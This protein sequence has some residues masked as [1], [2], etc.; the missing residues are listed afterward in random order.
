[1]QDVLHDHSVV[2]LVE[3][4]VFS[5]RVQHN[6]L[7]VRSGTFKHGDGPRWPADLST[8]AAVAVSGQQQPASSKQ[9]AASNKQQATS[10]NHSAGNHSKRRTASSEPCTS[11]SG[12]VNLDGSVPQQQQHSNDAPTV[13]A[14]VPGAARLPFMMPSMASRHSDARRTLKP[15]VYTSGSAMYCCTTNGLPHTPSW[16]NSFKP[17]F[18]NTLDRVRAKKRKNGVASLGS[19]SSAVKCSRRR[20]RESTVSTV[21]VHTPTRPRAQRDTHAHEHRERDTHAHTRTETHTETDAKQPRTGAAQNDAPPERLRLQ[22]DVG[23]DE[24][25]Q[26]VT[27]RR[28]GEVSGFN[29]RNSGNNRGT[30]QQEPRQLFVK[31]HGLFLHELQHLQGV[32]SGNSESM[33]LKRP[34]LPSHT[35]TRLHPPQ[36]G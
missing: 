9:Q 6:G 8:S 35:P 3:H 30:D 34:P 24:A 26:G 22:H 17:I 15:P 11:R 31:V 4:L 27:L 33:I 2:Q 1:M 7:V 21:H 10:S 23:G 16:D 13:S 36:G 5:V 18:G 28:G 32:Q 12:A 19:G 25:T 20:K 14:Q 29:R